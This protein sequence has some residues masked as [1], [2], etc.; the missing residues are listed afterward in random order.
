M[1]MP[2]NLVEMLD[3]VDKFI[4]KM[5][6]AGRTVAEE[7]YGVNDSWVAHGFTDLWMDG[8]PH[9][10]AQVTARRNRHAMG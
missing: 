5:V 10:D 4:S 2:S 8:S 1:A 6:E 7:Y 3:P 9:G